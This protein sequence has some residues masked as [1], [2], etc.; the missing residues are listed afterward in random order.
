MLI[1]D[2]KQIPENADA[3]YVFGE[4]IDLLY[5]FGRLDWQKQ[6]YYFIAFV[7]NGSAGSMPQQ[8]MPVGVAT[9]LTANLFARTGYL[10][11]GWSTSASG[12]R[13][14]TD[15][16]KVTNV[17][18]AGETATLYAL[19]DAITWY[20]RYNANGGSGSMSDSA[21][22]YDVAKALTANAFS[23]TGYTFAYW[24]TSSSGSKAYS[25]GQSVKNLKS[26][27]GDILNLY[28]I[29]SAITYYV[30]FNA[31][32]GS[33]SMGNQ[34]FTYDVAAKLSANAF[35]RTGYLFASWQGS[36]AGAT[37]VFANAQEVVNLASESGA[38]V[39][40]Y[41][42][43]NAI[44]WYV[45]YNANGGSGS[46]A[47]STHKYDIAKALTANAFAKSG[48]SF[49]GWATSSSGAVVYSNQQ[50]VKNLRSTHGDILNLYAVWKT[51]FWLNTNLVTFSN[52]SANGEVNGNS[53]PGSDNGAWYL[54]VNHNGGVAWSYAICTTSA[55]SRQNCT[56]CKFTVYILDADAYVS[57]NGQVTY[58]VSGENI[59][60]I[61]GLGDSLTMALSTG[62]SAN[63]HAVQISAPYFY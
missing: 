19:W 49:I 24:A 38:V 3:Y 47:N 63:G 52:T 6:K 62:S 31:N 50:S 16:Q 48:S 21:H 22:E 61:S 10:F 32:G 18:A 57:I 25:D 1:V 51:P 11:Y 58:L 28:A 53:W 13:Q 29:W 15:G 4:N 40:L 41:A 9:A 60:D 36:V 46:M 56:R 27:Q 23:K 30:R 37:M 12:A 45:K 20:V 59:I 39:D 34:Q 33:G 44:T 26:T 14:Y 7:S 17:A 54:S 35:S 5:V 42:L 2:E 8:T 55:F 43:W